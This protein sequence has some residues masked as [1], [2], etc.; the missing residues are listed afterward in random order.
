[1]EA[2]RFAEQDSPLKYRVRLASNPKQGLISNPLFE[3]LSIHFAMS[4]SQYAD[5]TPLPDI[6]GEYPETYTQG[7]RMLA[8]QPDSPRPAGVGG[9]LADKYDGGSASRRQ[10]SWNTILICTLIIVIVAAAVGSGVG[11]SLAVQNAR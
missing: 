3:N 7:V 4:P 6:H 10:Q 9:S 8:P 2:A 1:M 11:G 5:S